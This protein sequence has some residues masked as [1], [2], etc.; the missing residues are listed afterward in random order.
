MRVRKVKSDGL[1]CREVLIV[2]EPYKRFDACLKTLKKAM[3]KVGIEYPE[4]YLEMF[5]RNIKEGDGSGYIISAPEE[6][7]GLLSGECI[8]KTGRFEYREWMRGN[9]KLGID[10][11]CGDGVIYVYYCEKE[12]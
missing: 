6:C 10:V 2:R 4:D 1:V 9:Y 5:V 12:D 11:D 3:K 7:R 8:L